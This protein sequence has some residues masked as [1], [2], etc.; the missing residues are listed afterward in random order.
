[1]LLIN[2]FVDNGHKMEKYCRNI[3]IIIAKIKL[4][5]RVSSFIPEQPSAKSLIFFN[6][7]FNFFHTGSDPTRNNE[8][9]GNYFKR[10]PFQKKEKNKVIYFI[11][12]LSSSSM[13]FFSPVFFSSGFFDVFFIHDMKASN[14]HE[15]VE[16]ILREKSSLEKNVCNILRTYEQLQ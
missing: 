7:F 8:V 15:Y 16:W 2:I 12:P 10:F 11:F 4:W 13:D 14:F 6:G 1:M 3:I 5:K 9:F